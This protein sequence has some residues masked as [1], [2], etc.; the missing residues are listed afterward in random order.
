MATGRTRI[1]FV[2]KSHF[3][4]L[5]FYFELIQPDGQALAIYSLRMDGCRVA[6][7]TADGAAR[8]SQSQKFTRNPNGFFAR[9]EE[10]ILKFSKRSS[11]AA[12]QY[13]LKSIFFV[14]SRGAI[15]LFAISVRIRINIL[16]DLWRTVLPFAADSASFPPMHRRAAFITLCKYKHKKA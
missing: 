15:L 8:S 2:W 3:H 9:N 7:R 4:G 16:C 5:I 10:K 12:K 6:T 13:G 11:R 1:E 14:G